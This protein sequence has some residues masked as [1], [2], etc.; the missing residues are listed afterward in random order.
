MLNNYI[1][2]ITRLEN[3]I[4]S[5][6]DFNEIRKAIGYPVITN[7]FDYIA[8]EEQIKEYSI[9]PALQEF[10]RW[11]PIKKPLEIQVSSNVPTEIECEEDTIGI[12]LQQ[13]IPSSSSLSSMGDVMNNGIFLGNPFASA[14][15][16]SMMNQFSRGFGTVFNYE[17]SNFVYQNRFLNE[18][19]EAMNS[20]YY[21]NYD[22]IQNKVTVKSLLPGVFYL[23]LATVDS[24]VSKIPFRL[25][26]SFI[27][28]AQSVLLENFVYILG[29][30]ETEL[31]ST[32]DVDRLKEKSDQLKEEVLTYWR[33]ASFSPVLR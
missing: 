11:F 20:G 9:A 3:I 1:N 26:Q 14:N 8:T 31:P 15:Q 7:E 2:M 23:E 22:E 4:I 27:K 19:T 18:S 5:D 17:F 25:K 21:I 12:L 33:E 28:Y 32:I 13:F 10:Y 24:D 6:K 30:S 29:L 16:L